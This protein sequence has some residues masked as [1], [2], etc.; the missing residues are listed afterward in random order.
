MKT[1]SQFKV[2]LEKKNG[3]YYGLRLTRGTSDHEREVYKNGKIIYIRIS[4]RR[5]SG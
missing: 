3:V 2:E 4:H 1:I 5:T